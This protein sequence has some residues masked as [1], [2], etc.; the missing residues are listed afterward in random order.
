MVKLSINLF[1]FALD[2]LCIELKI[3]NVYY[4]LDQE[5]KMYVG[6]KDLTQYVASKRVCLFLS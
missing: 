5:K 2:I 1:A 3:C 4:C 6:Y